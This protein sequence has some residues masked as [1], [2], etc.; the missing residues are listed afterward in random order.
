M[1]TGNAVTRISEKGCLGPKVSSSDCWLE[2]S[3]RKG[4]CFRDVRFVRGV[5]GCVKNGPYRGIFGK[6]TMMFSLEGLSL[7]AL[8][9]QC[10][11]TLTD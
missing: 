9:D 8:A 2:A 7:G 10:S 5:C 3:A 6:F 1:C 11:S 4:D